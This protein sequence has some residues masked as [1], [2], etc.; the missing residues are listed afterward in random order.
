M[1]WWCNGRGWKEERNYL[2]LLLLLQQQQ[3]H[4]QQLHC[5]HLPQQLRQ[6]NWQAEEAPPY[7]PQSTPD[8]LQDHQSTSLR[9]DRMCSR[10]KGR[11][12]RIESWRWSSQC[13]SNCVLWF[14]VCDGAEAVN[15]QGKRED[16][17]SSLQRGDD[18]FR[19][20][21]VFAARMALRPHHWWIIEI[22]AV[23]GEP[24]PFSCFVFHRCCWSSSWQCYCCC[25]RWLVYELRILP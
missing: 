13:R 6:S 16:S 11:V 19:Q 24:L 12:F 1:G 21:V 3:Q 2:I 20:L 25:S 23:V 4:Q 14:V 10:R 5:Y 22:V 7:P 15:G 18:D 17:H 8:T 9:Q